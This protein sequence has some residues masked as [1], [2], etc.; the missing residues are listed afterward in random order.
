MAHCPPELLDDLTAVLAAVRTWTGVVE[1]KPGIFYLRREP[2]L[3]FHLVD[4]GRRRADVKGRAGW[5]SVDL[6]RPTSTT[7][8]RTFLREV[9]ARYGER[10]TPPRLTPRTSTSPPGAR[11]SP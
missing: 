7:R 5:V 6:P 2:F 11:R 4:G 8:R 3:H 9:Q 1:K 10:S